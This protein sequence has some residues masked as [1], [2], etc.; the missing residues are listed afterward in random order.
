MF[1]LVRALS[2]PASAGNDS[3]FFGWFIGNTARSDPSSTY[4]SALWFITFADRSRPW[5]VRDV[6]EVSRFSCMLFLDVR[7]FLDYAGPVGRW[8]CDAACRV[9]FPPSIR[10]RRT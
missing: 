7:G 2:S 10:G 8:R 4:M 5:L 6:K 9:A 1:S 3:P